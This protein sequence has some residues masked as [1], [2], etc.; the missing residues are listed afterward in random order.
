M[1]AV[2]READMSYI[3]AARF[4]IWDKAGEAAEKLMQEGFSEDAIHTF[5]VNPAGAHAKFPTGGDQMA[6]PDATGGSVGA[7]G[8]GAL[9]GV[10]GAVAG[11]IVGSL[12]QGNIYV[13]IVATGVGAYLGSLIG[14]M[15][16]IGRG[17]KKN[18]FGISMMGARP[19]GQ[20]S[21]TADDSD[22][23]YEHPAIRHA[24]VTLAVVADPSQRDLVTRILRETGG[25][26]VERAAGRWENGKW[27]DFD[28]VKPP[29]LVDNVRATSTPVQPPSTPNPSP[30]NY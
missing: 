23:D 10:V 25:V 15:G 24:G 9:L 3:I 11:A 27:A 13:L 1:M 28:P 14:A 29:E 2:T 18:A 30:G 22:P 16:L 20:A 4:E 21:Q 6:D 5:Y 8:G 26:D 7:W 17:R 12:V 19:N